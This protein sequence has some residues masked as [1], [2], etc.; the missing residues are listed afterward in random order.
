[1]STIAGRN[2]LAVS[3]DGKY[4]A[5]SNQGYIRYNG[6]TY[7]K[8]WGHMPSTIVYIHSLDSTYHQVIPEINDLATNIRDVNQASTTTSCSFSLDNKK[9]MMVGNDGVVIIRNLKFV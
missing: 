8:E 2:F 4:I 3:P 1:L 9:L 5:L 6:G 7:G